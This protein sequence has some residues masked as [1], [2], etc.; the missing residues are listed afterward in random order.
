[1]KHIGD[2]LRYM[3]WKMDDLT[4]FCQIE[5]YSANVNSLKLRF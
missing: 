2:I 5:S 1:M 3:G 4:E